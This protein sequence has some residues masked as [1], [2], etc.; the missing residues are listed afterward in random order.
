MGMKIRF[1]SIRSGY[2]AVLCVT[3]AETFFP[4]ITNET[5]GSLREEG[6]KRAVKDKVGIDSRENRGRMET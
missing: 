5:N 2:V 4:L 6:G 3:G 1:D